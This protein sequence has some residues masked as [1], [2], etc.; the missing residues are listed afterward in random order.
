MAH[1]R[2]NGAATAS[3]AGQ[4]QLRA[5]LGRSLTPTQRCPRLRPPSRPL[6]PAVLQTASIIWCHGLGDTNHGWADILQSSVSL[7]HIRWV[8]PNAPTQ[9]VTLNM[10]MSMPSWFD[11]RGLDENMQEAKEDIDEAVGWM[12]ELARREVA[13]GIPPERV[14]VGGFSQGGAMA[15]RTLLT[16]GEDLKLGG[17]VV[18]SSWLTL[19]NEYEGRALSEHAIKAPLFWAHGT[20]DMVVHFDRGLKSKELV[21]AMGKEAI[22]WR[23]YA[24]MAHSSCPQEIDHL[25]AWLKQTLPGDFKLPAPSE[26]EVRRLKVGELKKLITSRGGSFAGLF[27]KSELIEAALKLI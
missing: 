25:G 18:L 10:G 12:L 7:P 22:E 24:G 13:A 3:G 23:T 8:F 20:G 19:R 26:D 4:A 11:I 16:A 27:E 2:S 1:G 15:L 5:P 9:A 6:L 14:V 21:E 17:A